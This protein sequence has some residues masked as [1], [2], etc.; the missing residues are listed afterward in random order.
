[1]TLVG[2]SIVSDGPPLNL[3]LAAPRWSWLA[4]GPPPMLL[5]RASPSPALEGQR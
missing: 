3:W 4:Q 5:A 1:M 2:S